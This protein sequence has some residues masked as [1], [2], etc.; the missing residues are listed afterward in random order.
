MQTHTWQVELPQ[1]FHISRCTLSDRAPHSICAHCNFIKFINF[2]THLFP[3]DISSL[4]VGSCTLVAWSLTGQSRVSAL[5]ITVLEI[6]AYKWTDKINQ[7]MFVKRFT[8]YIVVW[9][10][11]AEVM[12]GGMRC[13]A[14]CSGVGN[15]SGIKGSCECP[16]GFEGDGCQLYVL[17]DCKWSKG[18]LMTAHYQK[19]GYG[20]SGPWCDIYRTRN[21]I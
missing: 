2:L 1:C 15:C 11:F 4:S 5:G 19:D 6:F 8:A 16:F 3:P 17:D 21:T 18:R 7:M 12:G 20:R 13:P 14:D 10:T 9:R